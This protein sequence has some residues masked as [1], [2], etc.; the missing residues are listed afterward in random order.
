MESESTRSN[1]SRLGTRTIRSSTDAGDRDLRQ[2]DPGPRRVVGDLADVVSTH[3][4][5]QG[6]ERVGRAVR[7]SGRER[8][9]TPRRATTS[10]TVSVSSPASSVI[11]PFGDVPVGRPGDRLQDADGRGGGRFDEVDLPEQASGRSECAGPPCRRRVAVDGERRSVPGGERHPVAVVARSDVGDVGVVHRDG[12]PWLVAAVGVVG[13]VEHVELLVARIGV[14]AD[15]SVD[16]FERTQ[17]RAHGRPVACL[18]PVGV[19]DHPPRIRSQHGR[20]EVAASPVDR[21]ASMRTAPV[22]RGRGAG[23]RRG[24]RCLRRCRP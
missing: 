11:R 4:E 23:R 10:K 9:A 2:A 5:P 12:L 13:R 16:G 14:E 15:R 20:V 3:L 17:V 22:G 24:R 7:P 21:R 19:G 1:A 8:C 6:L 18:A